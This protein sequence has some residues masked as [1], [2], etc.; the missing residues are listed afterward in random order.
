MNKEAM[1]RM[2]EAELTAY[3]S[4]LGVSVAA[5]NGAEEIAR[6]IEHYRGRKA[7][8]RAVGL[9][10]VVSVKNLRDKRV[11]DLLSKENPTDE[12]VTESMRLVLGDE[13]MEMVVEACTDDDG[14]VDVDAM[15]FAF[16]SVFT[17]EELKNY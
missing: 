5:A 2:T 13:Q 7:N 9:D 15:A 11:V 8:V 4:Q 1:S 12:E 14:T 16:C 6:L 3:A 17:S 10:L